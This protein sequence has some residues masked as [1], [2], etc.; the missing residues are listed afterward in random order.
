MPCDVSSC[1]S[2]SQLRRVSAPVWTTSSRQRWS[3]LRPMTLL[4][5]LVQLL[6]QLFAIITSRLLAVLLMTLVTKPAANATRSTIQTTTQ[7]YVIIVT[8]QNGPESETF[9]FYYILK[10]APSC[11]LSNECLTSCARG[12]TICL[13]PLQVDNIFAFI[14]QVAVLFRHNNIF[15]FIRQLAPGPAC[16]LF[17]TSAT[18]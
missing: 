7:R 14:R 18:S 8:P 15:V 3:S 16:W 11:N 2:I 10:V 4:Q 17:K 6:L 1:Y 9:V 5:I 13:R 12:D